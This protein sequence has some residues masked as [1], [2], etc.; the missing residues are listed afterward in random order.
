[1]G[2]W[3]EGQGPEVPAL[4]PY[5]PPNPQKRLERRGLWPRLSSH[6]NPVRGW[7]RELEGGIVSG[8]RPLAPSLK[9]TFLEVS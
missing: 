9:M 6:F 2:S 1:M 5:P 4:P 3:G 7:G 8:L